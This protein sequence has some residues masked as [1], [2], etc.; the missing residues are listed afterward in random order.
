MIK[1]LHITPNFYYT[2]GRSK[3]VYYYLKHFSSHPNYEV[4][5]ITN[6][7]DSLE[8][9]SDLPTVKFS[10]MKFS[11]G[12]KN[13][14]YTRKFYLNLKKYVEENKIDLIHT[15]HRFPE[16]VS[17]IIGKE[18]N[19]RT[20]TSAHS[21]VRKFNRASFKSDKIISVSESVSKYLV[22]NFNLKRE[23][24]ITLFNP[25]DKASPLD[26][27]LC[28]MF[29]DKNKISADKKL[30]LFVGRISK[31]KGYDTLLK[32]FAFV[33]NTNKN[34][35][36][37]INGLTKNKKLAPNS[38]ESEIIKILPQK[39][40][41]HLYFIADLIILPSRIDPFPLV[42]LEAGL[43]KKPFIGGNTGGIAEF[44]E[45]GNNGLLVNPNN[46]KE[47]ADKIIYLLNNPQI[48]NKL[49]ENLYQKVSRLCDYRNYFYQV[50][51][52]YSNLLSD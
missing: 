34:V 2:C 37:L 9:L 14:F 50:E 33:R 20:I 25:A 47:L 38:D 6:G 40:I 35:V 18:L 48:A 12:Y 32:S 7:G 24:I 49:G 31:E 15:H 46:P 28:D 21:F 30:V 13:I 5:F 27:I 52:I 41:R 39:D 22:A 19:I 29:K 42:M 1:I 3:L 11:T 45:D 23:K 10:L 26:T 36:L 8:R 16:Y 51:N 43:F 44:I 17:V 4:H